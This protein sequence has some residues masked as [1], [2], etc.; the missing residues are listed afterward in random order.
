[1]GAHPALD[2]GQGEG[3][4]SL[5]V[6]HLDFEG[7]VGQPIP[8]FF[9]GRSVPW[10]VEFETCVCVTSPP[11]S[12]P[13]WG[14]LVPPKEPVARVAKPQPRPRLRR[15]SLP[16]RT[17]RCT[18]TMPGTPRARCAGRATNPSAPISR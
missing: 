9:H 15:A 11:R 14:S 12:P 13:S 7:G 17:S 2:V 6:S 5:I 3:A 1:G 16:S 10:R 4:L 18:G 8:P